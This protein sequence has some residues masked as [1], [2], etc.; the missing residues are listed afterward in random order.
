[1]TKR[2]L[3]P[4]AFGQTLDPPKAK[5]TIIGLC[6][7]GRIVGAIAP[8]A[9]RNAW[10]IPEGARIRGGGIRTE[11]GNY[12]GISVREYANLHGRTTQR[13]YG[14]LKQNR[15]EGA[16]KTAHGWDLPRDAPWP[17]DDGF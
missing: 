13:V 3:S 9:D 16:R 6:R 14:L 1:M 17:A 7:E 4:R 11:Y 12:G 5:T 2:L 15:I 8:D 10:L